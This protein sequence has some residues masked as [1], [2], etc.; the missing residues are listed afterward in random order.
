MLHRAAT[1]QPISVSKSS[2]STQTFLPEAVHAA[3]E[4]KVAEFLLKPW[5][6]AQVAAAERSSGDTG[7]QVGG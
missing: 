5:E 1:Q 7:T 6:A 4:L 2:L 3:F